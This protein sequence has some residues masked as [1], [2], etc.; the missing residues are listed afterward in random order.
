MT[1]N[2][3]PHRNQ[4]SA[5]RISCGFTFFL[6]SASIVPWKGTFTRLKK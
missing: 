2:M 1:V 4:K 6:V 5:R 3:A